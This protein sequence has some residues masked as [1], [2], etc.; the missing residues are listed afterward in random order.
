MSGPASSRTYW[1]PDFAALQALDPEVAQGLLT[2]LDRQRG[3]LQLIASENFA[4]PAVLAAQGSVL[5][6][7]Y[8]EG[9]PGKRYYGGCEEAVDPLEQLAIDR[10]KQLFGA[11]HANVQ[12]HSGASANIAAYFATVSPGD[13]VLAMS[14][15]HGGHLTHG[16]KLNFSGKWFDV[17]SYGVRQDTE[18]IDMDEVRALALEH[19]PKL[20][21]AGWSAYPRQLDFEAFRAIA[22]EVDAT[23]MC[24]AAHFIGLVAGG[25]H[26]SP[27]PWCDI[28]T[29]TTHKTL[30]GPRGAIIL[31]KEHLAKAVD[32][33][34]FPGTQGGPLEHVIAA[35][36]V[37]LKE[38]MDPSFKEYSQRIL[39]D[40]R[41]LA[42]G[43]TDRG[44][45]VTSGG[46]DTHLFLADV[47]GK[48]LTG[49]EA[50]ARADAAGIVL[51]K[52]AIPFDQNPPA[53]ASGIRAGT[54]TV[55]TQGMGP[56]ELTAVAGLIDRALTG[57]DEDRAAVRGEVTDLV[58]R[59]PAYPEPP[60]P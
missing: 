58:G 31:A 2:E 9:Y 47:T 24:D 14:L 55:A 21:I 53:V 44:Y 59:F 34:V 38:A 43:L 42:D 35:K 17:A 11:D 46:T 1:G 54:A 36:A 28:V 32:K 30:R 37:A 16:M 20:I 60:R 39:D 25:V 27:V 7:K 8:A 41:A 52:N 56:D 26:P 6:N 19:R 40:A 48:G 29:F 13:K 50:E 18:V 23:L 49:A 51:N 45:R 10:A 5:T 12:P 22:D 15:P 4:S 33:A 57:T 3:K